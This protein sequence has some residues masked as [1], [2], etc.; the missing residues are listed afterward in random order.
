MKKKCYWPFSKEIYRTL[1]FES[2]QVFESLIFAYSHYFII[3]DKLLFITYKYY[4]KRKLHLF[5]KITH[6]RYHKGSLFVNII[7][8]NYNNIVSK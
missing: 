5:S 8:L 3:S 1:K 7:H 6:L 4:L 2:N